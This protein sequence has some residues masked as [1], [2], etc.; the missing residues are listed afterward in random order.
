MKITVGKIYKIICDNL[1]VFEYKD[2][3]TLINNTIYLEKNQIFLVLED[4]NKQLFIDYITMNIKQQPGIRNWKI[5]HNNQIYN[6]V[7]L[8]RS[9]LTSLVE[10]LDIT[11]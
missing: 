6:L 5:L 4:L 11:K 3:N 9:N 8:G 10:S 2:S 7:V 1:A